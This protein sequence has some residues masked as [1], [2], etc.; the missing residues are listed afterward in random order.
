MVGVEQVVHAQKQGDAV[1]GL[2]GGAQVDEAVAI[3]FRLIVPLV[4][5]D[6]VGPGATAHVIVAFPTAQGV[7]AI[8]ALD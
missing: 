2:I 4:A 8:S 1:G 5:L 6:L 3:N 7:V